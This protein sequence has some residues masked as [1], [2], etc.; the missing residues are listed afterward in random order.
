MNRWDGLAARSVLGGSLTAGRVIV[1]ARRPW[2][3]ASEREGRC[4]EATAAI[5]FMPRLAE[6]S[7]KLH[8]NGHARSKGLCPHASLV[9]NVRSSL[10]TRSWC[11]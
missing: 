2:H 10:H 6:R 5:P 11:V 9:T 4:D 8:F 3:V 1:I 7:Q